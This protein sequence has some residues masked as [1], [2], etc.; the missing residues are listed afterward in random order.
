MIQGCKALEKSNNLNFSRKALLS[1]KVQ[2]FKIVVRNNIF[3][4]NDKIVTA[5]LRDPA[6]DTSFSQ[7][8]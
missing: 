4:Y 2:K 7:R 3:Q 1:S 5:T 6:N 8:M